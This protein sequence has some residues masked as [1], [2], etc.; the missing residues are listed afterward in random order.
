MWHLFS[1][2]KCIYYIVL[3]NHSFA[4]AYSN[5]CKKISEQYL[6][7]VIQNSVHIFN[8]NSIHCPSNIIHGGHQTK[9][10]LARKYWARIPIRPFRLT[11]SKQSTQLP[12]GDSL[13]L[14]TL[15]S[16]SKLF[17]RLMGQ[18]GPT[19]VGKVW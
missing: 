3:T 9:K 12:H 15:Y 2:N 19:Q 4:R 11:W 13:G 16:S 10:M 5:S 6:F 14:L 7:I 17:H 18:E 1:V 8:P